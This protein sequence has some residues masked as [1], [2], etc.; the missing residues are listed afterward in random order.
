MKCNIDDLR[1]VYV[2]YD[3]LSIGDLEHYVLQQLAG[4]KSLNA[5][6]SSKHFAYNVRHVELGKRITSLLLLNGGRRVL[7][8]YIRVWEVSASTAS[9]R[10][11]EIARR[12]PKFG[13]GAFLRGARAASVRSMSP[14]CSPPRLH[15]SPARHTPP[16]PPTSSSTRCSARCQPYIPTTCQTLSEYNT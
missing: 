11:R 15:P 6:F 13:L 8:L 4:I 2:S 3:T 9:N 5:T 10:D 7:I 12:L 14:R 1:I 16:P